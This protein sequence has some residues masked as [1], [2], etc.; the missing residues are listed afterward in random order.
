MKKLI[1][2]EQKDNTTYSFLI[3]SI[4]VLSS[5]E[6]DEDYVE[7]LIKYKGGTTDTITTTNNQY[8]EILTIWG[9]YTDRW[10]LW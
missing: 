8:Q 9:K 4:L 10:I 5:I 7:V 3:S 2:V 6:K 1:V